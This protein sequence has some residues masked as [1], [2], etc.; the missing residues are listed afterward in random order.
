LIHHGKSET[1]VDVVEVIRQ[2]RESRATGTAE[3]G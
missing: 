1:P 2:E 3:P